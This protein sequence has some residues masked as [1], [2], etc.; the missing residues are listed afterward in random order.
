MSSNCVGES[1][2]ISIA[3]CTYNGAKYLE[4]QLNS[5]SRQTILPAELVVCDDGSIDST[6]DVLRNFAKE[7]PFQ[8][9][10]YENDMNLGHMQNFS[11]AISLCKGNY[12][13]LS[14]QDDVWLPD[15][16]EVSL[17]GMRVVEQ[18]Y[19]K[20]TPIL[21]YTD[22]TVVD[23][24]CRVIHPSFMRYQHLKNNCFLSS[25]ITQ[26]C[27]TGCCCLMNRTLANEAVP[28]PKGAAMH[29]WWLA[30]IATTRGRIQYIEKPTIL[31]RQHGKNAV[32]A[33]GP[34]LKN[35][36]EAFQKLNSDYLNKS[37]MRLYHQANQLKR[38]L[39][40]HNEPVPPIIETFA[41]SIRKGGIDSVMR[42]YFS[43]VRKQRL[44]LDVLFGIV[45][46]L[47][48]YGREFD[49]DHT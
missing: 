12:I 42:L 14:D 5:F 27:V 33:K 6:C 15:K 34:I 20:N 17:Q 47:R 36:G 37:V 49:R 28:I 48:T 44:L 21:V 30:L 8:V 39:L 3:L 7:A 45:V 18:K 41:S 4:E 26:N 16:N 31:Y 22:L 23:S 29:D 10:I 19:G 13:A 43:G 1:S 38:H 2:S 9:H 32:G 40:D 11:K 46:T 24:S 35:L 25:L